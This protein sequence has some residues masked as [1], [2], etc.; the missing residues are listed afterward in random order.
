[1]T[2]KVGNNTVR[3]IVRGGTL[4]IQEVRH[5]T[6]LIWA[7]NFIGDNFDRDDVDNSLG[8]DW[9]NIGPSGD[10]LLS[11]ENNAARVYMPDGLIG[12]FWDARLA[13]S[14]WNK[15]T[16]DQDNGYIEVRPT[17][18][19]DNASFWAGG[20]FNSA[21][22]GRCNASG[23]L[24]HGV[25]INLFAGQCWIMYA[26]NGQGVFVGNGGTFQA[27]NLIRLTFIDYTFTLTVNGTTRTAWTDSNHIT[28]KGASY[29]SLVIAGSAGKD[30]F[31][32][33]RYSPSLDNVVMG[34]S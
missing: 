28:A 27:G 21:V 18:K 26:V 24:T 13:M 4:P 12:G 34:Y 17:S 10:R 2:L 9:T 19:G 11:I 6:D 22:L 23:A 8:S 30:L 5:G 15:G 3:Q 20:G 16:L 29:R 7:Y 32:P 31:G 25:G 1:M 33:R 14:R